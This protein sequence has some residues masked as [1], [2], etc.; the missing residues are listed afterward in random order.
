[1]T[2]SKWRT[3]SPELLDTIPEELREK[4]SLQLLAAPGDC[5][6]ALGIHWDTG[7]DQ[8]HDAT[9]SLSPH[10]GPTKR[11]VVS[12]VARTFDI[13]GWF[14]PAVVIVKI[15]LQKLWKLGM[16]WDE[17]VP[18]SL[19]AVWR[20][21]TDELHYITDHPIARCYYSPDKTRLH[22]QLHG[23]SNASNVAYGGVV[24]VMTLYKDTT[25]S[26]SMV[27]AKTKVAPI[28]PAGTTPRLELCGAQILS[29]LP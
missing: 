7:R 24:Y 29:K 10:A 3:N 6:K 12:D 1:M 13:L 14:S 23:F 4:D 8:F 26:V 9:P 19:A 2:L 11:Q 21:W 17:P 22:N 16:T 15:L 28:S 25:V 18:E 20:S 5:Q 27:L